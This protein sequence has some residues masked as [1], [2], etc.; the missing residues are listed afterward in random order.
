MT[1]L[2]HPAKAPSTDSVEIRVRGRVQGVGFRPFV[3]RIARESGL[4]G[5]VLNDAHGVLIRASGPSA[6]IADFT[7]RI[8][9]ESPPLARIEAIEVRPCADPL[10]D[11]FIIAGSLGGSAHTEIT[12]DAAMCPECATEI[13]DPFSRRYRY[14]FATCTHC[15]PRLTIVT[16]VP[17]DRPSTTMAPFDLCEACAAEYR[18][19]A[20][21]RFHAETTACH[22]CGP[23]ARLVRL[24]GR[25][26]SFEQHSML[27]DTDA[28]MSLI[29]KGEIVA[30]K[31]LGGY[32]I[33][34]DA[35]NTAAV[36][37]LRQRKKRDAKPF[38]L[39]AR[40]FDVIS[41]YCVMRPEE[42]KAL[43]SPE[44]PIVL[45][46]KN[47]AKS[48]PDAI[49]PGLS[50]LGFMLPT[51]PLHALL[52]RRMTRP[53]VMT[54]GNLSDEPQATDDDDARSRLA[55]IASYALVHDRGIANRVD[56]SVVRFAAGLMHVLRRSRGYA[57]AA[58]SLPKGFETAPEI[59]ALGAE[60]KSTFCLI[61]DGAAILSQH[62]GDLDDARTFD[63]YKQNLALFTRVYDCRVEALVA[64][65]HP[66][67]RSTK[68]ARE[69]ALA[70]HLPLAF[71]QHHHAHVTSCLAENGRP[72]DAPP[73]L[74][75]VLDGL[76]LGDDG[77]IWGGEFLLADYRDYRRLGTF[78][79]V[80][81]I[82][83]D[84]ASREPWRNLYAH[85]MAEMGWPAFALN[86]AELALF[87]DL[88]AKPRKLL[89]AMLREGTN[90][91]LASS[92]GRLFDAVAAAVGLCRENQGYE[93]QAAA[94]LEAAVD[95][96][97]LEHE[98][99]MLAYPFTIPRLKDSGIPY[100]EPL[101]VW[102]AILGDLILETPAG[103]IAARFHKGLA[104]VITAMAVKLADRDSSEGPRFETVALS[105]GCFQNRILIEEV[106]RRLGD[107]G[108]EVL[109]H[110]KVPANDGGVALGQ[111][112]IGVA[113][114]IHKNNKS[115]GSL[116]C[117]SAFPDA[118]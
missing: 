45:L 67:Y 19:P 30:I 36:A 58:M 96:Y 90:A 10:A 15:G 73:V 100:V 112:V 41:Q 32:Q 85:L 107:C 83:G 108:F 43:T 91:P 95:R 92:C 74:G 20:D 27:D 3:W 62:Q 31:G 69:K 2:L 34:C 115:R 28:A 26:V 104:R 53:V 9:R 98:H 93:G 5:D 106:V 35:T 61:K 50:T 39:M 17:Y 103:T 84:K 81:M 8:G 111:A 114:L 42:E 44:A 49:A 48:L 4:R 77:M 66:E 24:D 110:S 1:L 72:L 37:T 57:P 55:S 88:D 109:T 71:V 11:D 117:A 78:K 113:H 102:N 59:L 33:A 60:L 13:F 14:P 22:A 101:A 47:G 64:D 75:I 89:D 12:P 63:D 86:F 80:A 65:R 116:P 56:D 6:S 23:K 29:Q 94:Q 118:S 68:L 82:G 18:D 25:P 76:G 21:R 40:D 97:V 70:D 87:R 46:S 38:A 51:T 99:E 105:G 79:P 52:M 54:S 7:R 16:G